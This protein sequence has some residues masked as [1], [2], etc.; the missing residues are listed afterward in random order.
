M[1]WWRWNL[2]RQNTGYETFLFWIF[3][4]SDAYLLR[5]SEGTVIPPH[6]DPIKNKRHFRLNIVIWNAA[7]GGKFHC[8]NMIF[9]SK[10]FKFFRPDLNIHS[11]DPIKHGTRLV[12]SLGFALQ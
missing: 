9:E 10:R 11:V 6:T 5:Y 12:L 7:D 1:K 2:G 8:D 3:S 4:F